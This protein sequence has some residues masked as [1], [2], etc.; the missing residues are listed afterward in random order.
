MF[1]KI[2]SI[3]FANF[4]TVLMFVILKLYAPEGL[5]YLFC[6]SVCLGHSVNHFY[7]SNKLQTESARQYFTIQQLLTACSTIGQVVTRK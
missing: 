6:H 1:S 5:R 7:A 2:E 3:R 4:N